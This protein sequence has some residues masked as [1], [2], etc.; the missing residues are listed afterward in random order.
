[1]G[2]WDL[3]LEYVRIV[4]AS[5]K[6]EMRAGISDPVGGRTRFYGATPT[7]D[8]GQCTELVHCKDTARKWIMYWAC[9]NQVHPKYIQNFPGKFPCNSPAQEMAGTFKM[10]WVMLLRCP[11]W[12]IDGNILNF[13]KENNC[14]FPSGSFKGFL[15]FSLQCNH[16]LPG[17][18]TAMFPLG[19]TWEH[20]E[21]SQRK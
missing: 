15:W 9:A 3:A 7:G 19:N 17:H 16:S 20:L 5:I 4:T 13:P 6:R 10:S 21:F 8:K 1:M 2:A 14:N 18:V 11:H 12:E